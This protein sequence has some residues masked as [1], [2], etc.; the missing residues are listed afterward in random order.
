MNQDQRRLIARHNALSHDSVL[1]ARGIEDKI[2]K[3]Q[4][5]QSQ[6]ASQIS[7]LEGELRSLLLR[8]FYSSSIAAGR[9][10]TSRV[11][12]FRRVRRGNLTGINI[13]GSWYV[14]KEEVDREVEMSRELEKMI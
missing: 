7:L 1:K 4:E 13:A 3:L 9:L 6:I 11:T 12:V 8:D 14:V 5:E 10:Q 2:E